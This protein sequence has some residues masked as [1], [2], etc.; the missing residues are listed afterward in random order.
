MAVPDASDEAE[1]VTLTGTLA[2]FRT[3]LAE[4]IDDAQRA[5]PATSDGARDAR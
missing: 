3:A 5:T 2:E 4:E 1:R